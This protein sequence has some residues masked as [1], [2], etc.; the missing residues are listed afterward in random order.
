MNKKKKDHCYNYM[1]SCPQALRDDCFLYYV[2][3]AGLTRVGIP[4][5]AA[6][7]F[8]HWLRFNAFKPRAAIYKHGGNSRG[9]LFQRRD[10]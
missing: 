2:C 3:A 6:F 9:F 7:V 4:E 5:C 10:L 8:L 1:V